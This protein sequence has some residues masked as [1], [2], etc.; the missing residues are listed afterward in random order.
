MDAL[1]EGNKT[2]S[3]HKF[4]TMN[5]GTQKLYVCML[6][7]AASPEHNIGEKPPVRKLKSNRCVVLE[8]CKIKGC[9]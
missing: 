6:R 1:Q 7:E 2:D 8:P 9:R 3:R 5:P 4:H